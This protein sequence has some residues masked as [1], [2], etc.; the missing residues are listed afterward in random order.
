MPVETETYGQIDGKAVRA[1]TLT[2]GPLKARVIEYGATLVECHVPDAAGKTADIVLGHDSLADYQK[3]ATYFGTTAGRYG[4]RIRRGILEFDDGKTYQLSINEG[5]NHLHG[6][7]NGFH[8]KLWRGELVPDTDAVRFSYRSPDGEE[9]YPGTLDISVTYALTGDDALTIDFEATTDKPTICN[10]VHHS[11]WNLGG[12][13]SGDV[14][15]QE[16]TVFGDFY[17]PVDE[18]LLATGEILS[19][20]GTPFDFREPKTIGRDIRKIDNAGGGRSNDPSGGYDHNLVL[21]GEAGSLKP[22]IRAVDPVSGRGMELKTTEP[23]VQFYT[24]GYLN[25]SI[26]GKG[27]HGYCRYAGFTLETQ[28]FPCSPEFSHFPPARLNPGETYRQRMA[29]RFFAQPGT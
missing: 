12:H 29:F 22:C 24:G 2:R 14:L 26:I 15:G 13:A 23:G 21:R 5:K 17:V 3:T 16:L 20:A 19:V 27:G 28:K 7:I 25:P 1:F 8:S 18:E 11:Y 6:G 4:N 9:G 10:P